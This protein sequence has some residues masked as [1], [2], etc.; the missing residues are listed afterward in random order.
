M[1]TRHAWLVL[2]SYFAALAV[3]CILAPPATASSY[4]T[5]VIHNTDVAV[6]AARDCQAHLDQDRAP[7]ASRR[8]YARS[9]SMPFRL[10]ALRLWKQ[11]AHACAAKT[12]YLNALPP[13]AI[14]H[15]FIRL[16]WDDTKIA[17]D[18][19][20]DEAGSGGGRDFMAI[21]DHP[22][23]TNATLTDHL[24]CFQ[25]GKWA[26]DKYGFGPTALDQAWSAFRYRVGVG[27]WCSGWAATADVCPGAI[28]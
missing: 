2:L 24:G 14:V 23:C 17:L 13:R 4:S 3:A 19:A 26:R 20:G 15:V 11:R 18:V 1:S 25:E 6:R 21:W 9:D 16:G 10:W 7:D 22:F 12:R 28:Y 27:G 5:R 8:T